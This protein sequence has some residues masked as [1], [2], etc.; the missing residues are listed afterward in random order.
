M[1]YILYNPQANCGRGADGLEQVQAAFAADGAE[2]LD[3]LTQQTV[4]DLDV[5]N[6]LWLAKA[7]YGA[8]LGSVYMQTL[9]GEYDETGGDYVPDVPM[10][11][12]MVNAYCC[13]YVGGVG[14]EAS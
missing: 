9:P 2:L 6:F 7:V 14:M 11:Q 3:I 8:D 13:P 1:T 10:V 12:Q 5:R 4:T